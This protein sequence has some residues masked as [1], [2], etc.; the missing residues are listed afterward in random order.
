[1]QSVKRIALF[2][3]IVMSMMIIPAA[4]AHGVVITPTIDPATG[5]VTVRA[6]FDT[7][8]A[9]DEAQVAVFAPSDLI[10]PWLTG[11][12]D[13]D[14]VFTFDPDYSIEGT[15]D[16]QVRKAG[17]GGLVN[18]ALDSSMAPAENPAAAVSATTPDFPQALTLADGSRIIISGDAQFDV[19]GNIV[20]TSSGSISDGSAAANPLGDGFTPAQIAIMAVSVTWGFIGTGLYFSRRRK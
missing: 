16:I 5:A 15:W 20:I 10:T 6:A 2:I 7:G 13:A 18:V 12:T 1:M 11:V 14:G 8:E 9:L 3:S 4:S 19:T 17:H